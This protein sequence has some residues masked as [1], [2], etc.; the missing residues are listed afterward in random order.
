MVF[1]IGHLM[2]ELWV[3]TSPGLCV[4]KSIPHYKKLGGW[5]LSHHVFTGGTLQDNIGSDKVIRWSLG[6]EFK[7]L[8]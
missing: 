3:C 8:Y 7:W 1:K 2:Y 6:I 5:K 4:L